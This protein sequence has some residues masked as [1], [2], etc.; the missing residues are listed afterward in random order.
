MKT[1]VAMS[2]GV[3][4]A[5]CACI[6]KNK[7]EDVFGANL[8]LHGSDF[9]ADTKDIE[10][11]KAVCDRLCIPFY[12][13]DFSSDF[14]S[15]VVKDF[16]KT[17][18][19][20]G[21]PNPCVICNRYIKIQKLIEK[22]DELSCEKVATG[23]YANIE[24]DECS[25]RYLLKKAKDETKDQSYVLYQLTQQQL[26]RLEFP[27]GKLTKN[28]AREIARAEGLKNAER[29]DSQDICF[30]PDGDYYSFIEK[31]TGKKQEHGNFIDENGNVLGTHKGIINYTIGQRKGLG[32]SSTAPLFVTKI[33]PANNT[34][35]LTHG[36]GLFSKVLYAE[37][38]NLISVEEIKESMRVMAK[39]RYRQKAQ[40]ATATMQ[41]D[42]KLKVEFDE[43]QRAITKGQ[44]VVLYDG[45]IVVG[46]GIII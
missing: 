18:Q 3:D 25:G 28:D 12:S 1:L 37:N 8:K 2:G 17:Y 6:L 45:D 30:I 5:V 42:G 26:S 4:S 39:V 20:G 35:T 32:V 27:L 7:G 11:A 9:D 16:V 36:E 15:V 22:A 38:V 41:S 31:Y 43:E 14:E 44:S 21:T 29:A 24:F 13:F 34:V 46:G 23:H 40:S 19:N 33:N 10:D